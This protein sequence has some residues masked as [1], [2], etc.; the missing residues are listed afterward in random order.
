MAIRKLR[1]E[2]VGNSV[3]FPKFMWVNFTS[4]EESPYYHA[5]KPFDLDSDCDEISVEDLAVLKALGVCTEI[6]AYYPNGDKYTVPKLA[7]EDDGVDA[8]RNALFIADH[9]RVDVQRLS[10]NWVDRGDDGVEDY[11]LM[12][13]LPENSPIG[14]TLNPDAI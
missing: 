10:H 6:S 4:D 11:W 9:F 5:S 14:Q 12:I 2:H 13:R 1:E 3:G 8:K 7:N